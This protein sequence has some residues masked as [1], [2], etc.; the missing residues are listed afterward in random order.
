VYTDTD[1]KS[2]ASCISR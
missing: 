1:R 2:S